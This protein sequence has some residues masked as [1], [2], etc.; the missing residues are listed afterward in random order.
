MTAQGAAPGTGIP[1]Q[2]QDQGNADTVPRGRA[3]GQPRPPAKRERFLAELLRGPRD[4]RQLE[5]EP[6]FDHVAPSTASEL[7]KLGVAIESRRIEV[8]GFQGLP[9]WI[10]Q[11]EI[12]EH[13]RSFAIWL[14]GQMRERRIRARR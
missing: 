2:R 1:G 11:Y 7:K 10:A 14:L 6:V 8:K 9:A 3:A 4:S 5:S 13:G 12:P